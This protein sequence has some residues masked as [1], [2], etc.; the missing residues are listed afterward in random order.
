MTTKV[1][2]D[3]AVIGIGHWGKNI[4]RELSSLT[5]LSSYAAKGNPETVAW[6]N[7]HASHVKHKTLLEIAEDADITTVFIATPIATHADIASQM[8]DAGKHV[9]VE[10]PLA[11]NV[12]GAEKL[13]TLAHIKQ[14]SLMTGYLLLYHPIYQELKKQIAGQPISRVECVWEKY[15]SFGESIELNLL[16]HHLA[17]AYDLL[18]VPHAGH[19]TKRDAY[20]T[21]CDI[22]ETELMY[23]DCVVESRINRVSNTKMHRI[24][25]EVPQAVYC[26][27]NTTLTKNGELVLQNFTQPLALELAAF[28]AS[29]VHHTQA[30][31]SGGF[32]A[33]VLQIHELLAQ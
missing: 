28:L 30:P 5:N 29:V 33:R 14:C 21:A 6:M 16:T 26:W 20:T 32:G 15:G 19:Y 25:V 2:G 3:S 17:L 12:S 24:T 27:D 11:E 1:K 10:K 7:T 18:G 22:I 13:V 8:L 9:F 23:K 4:V 31:S